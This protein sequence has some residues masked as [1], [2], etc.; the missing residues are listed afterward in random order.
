MKR[1]VRLRSVLRMESPTRRYGIAPVH[2]GFSSMNNPVDL[3]PDVLARE[4]A[5][6]GFESFWVGEHPQ[7]PVARTTPYP[8]GGEM[9]DQ[10]RCMMDPFLSL[11]LAATANDDLV[12]GTSVALPLEHDVFDLAKKVTTLDRL[13]GG[14]FQFGVGVGWNVEELANHRAVRWPRRYRA[15][16][17]CVG[18]LRALWCDNESEFH[19]EFYD[20]DPVWSLPKPLQSPHP[21]VLCGTGGRLGTRE[22]VAWADGWMP[23]DVALGDVHKKVGLFRAAAENAGRD[24]D[25]IPITMVAFGDRDRRELA[26][27]REL[28]VERVIVGGN[29][30]GWDDPSTTL[31]CLD[32]Y[33]AMIPDLA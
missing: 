13:S 17:E 6:R 12:V 23:M 19:G 5:A 14:R 31:P 4:L 20:F 11:L 25:V 27:Y 1:I 3:P 32:H 7:I 9:P 29:R 18:A 10:Y 8:A 21:P 2:L 26:D 33:A 22:A 28:G 24:P 15:L 16:A 30:T